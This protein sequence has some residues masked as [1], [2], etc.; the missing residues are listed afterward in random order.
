METFSFSDE[1]KDQSKDKMTVD[2]IQDGMPL[3][4]IL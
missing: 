4:R 3:L 2:S 1:Y